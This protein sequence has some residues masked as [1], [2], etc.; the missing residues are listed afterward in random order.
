MTTQICRKQRN[1]K[2]FE[3]IMAKNFKFNKKH[4]LKVQETQL[5]TSRINN[6]S[7]VQKQHSKIYFR[8]QQIEIHYNRKR[9]VVCHI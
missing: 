6:K 4:Y 8:Q 7:N 5:P 3:E 2:V 1:R 9:K